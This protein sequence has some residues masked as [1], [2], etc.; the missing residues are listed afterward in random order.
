[1]CETFSDFSFFTF[2]NKFFW[3]SIS[4]SIS[5]ASGLW[6]LINLWFI[7][8]SGYKCYQCQTKSYAP[9][10]PRAA[11]A[12]VWDRAVD[13]DKKNPLVQFGFRD[14]AQPRSWVA[15][16]FSVYCCHASIAEAM[17]TISTDELAAICFICSLYLSSYISIQNVKN[18]SYKMSNLPILSIRHA[19]HAKIVILAKQTFYIYASAWHVNYI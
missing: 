6:A 8:G 2:S 18:I 4:S 9:A 10:Q 7:S 12:S 11:G 17:P 16:Q 14:N 3:V 5:G 15:F 13:S 1:M 19:K